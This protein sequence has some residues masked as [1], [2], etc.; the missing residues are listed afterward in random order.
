[1][2]VKGNEDERL[3]LGLILY[4]GSAHTRSQLGRCEQIVDR[5]LGAQGLT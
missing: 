1:M 2:R 4:Y 3:D 5:G